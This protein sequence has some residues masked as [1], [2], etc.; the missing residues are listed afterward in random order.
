VGKLRGR[1]E[2]EAVPARRQH[3]PVG[4]G[5][6]QA[7]REIVDVDDG[8]DD[9]AHRLRV[10]RGLEPEVQGTALV[11]LEMAEADPADPRGI[12]DPGDGLPD[13]RE[14]GPVAGISVTEGVLN[15]NMRLLS[16]PIELRPALEKTRSTDSSRASA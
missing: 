1:A 4:Q 6:G 3:V 16:K 2:A 14:G 5:F 13:R 12:E 9:A 11:G 8:P 7:G 15:A 10:R